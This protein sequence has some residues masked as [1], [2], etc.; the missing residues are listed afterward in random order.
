MERTDSDVQVWPAFTDVLMIV[1]LV[2]VFYLF[3]Q[4][5]IIGQTLQG[6]RQRQIE[7][8]EAVEKTVPS[9]LRADLKISEDGS[10][11][12]YTFADRILFDSGKADLKASGMV[13]LRAL[14]HVFKA[15]E[16][17][18]AQIQ[19]E[20]HTD[21]VDIKGLFPSNWEL[22]SAR[23]TSVVHFFHDDCGLDEHLLSATGLAEFHPVDPRDSEEARARNRRI[24]VVVIYSVRP[25]TAGGAP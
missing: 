17:S 4:A 14:G 24:E 15:H 3:A 22:S 2:L 6:I 9:F 12:R 20:G 5:T 1:T 8:R 16:K 18:V 13:A 19:V 7:L 23:A 21:N 10:I 25:G 11:Q